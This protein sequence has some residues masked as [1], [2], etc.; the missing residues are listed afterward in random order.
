MLWLDKNDFKMKEAAT[1]SPLLR[2]ALN[3]VLRYSPLQES[4]NSF[5]KFMT[6]R[7]LGES[8]TYPV[9]SDFTWMIVCI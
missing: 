8:T 1:I 9:Q 3:K 5:I 6:C 7:D 4:S 2:L